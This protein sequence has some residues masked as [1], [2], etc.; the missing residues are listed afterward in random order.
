[1]KPAPLLRAFAVIIVIAGLADPVWTRTAS[2][3]RRLTVVVIEPKPHTLPA[4]VSGLWASADALR[5]SLESDYEISMATHAR[6]HR[7]SACPAEGGCLIVSNGS[8]PMRVSAGAKVIGGLQVGDSSGVAIERIDRPDHVN[9]LGVG[10]LNVWLRSA[11]TN[12]SVVISAFDEG[13]LVGERD[14]K[15]SEE[16]VALDWVPLTGGARRLRVVAS[17]REGDRLVTRDSADV[18]IDVDTAKWPL[19]MYEPEPTWLG[20]FVRRSVEADPR[21]RL[22]AQ[23]RF[24]P[25]VVIG[26][27][28][29]RALSLEA[30]RD[31]RAVIVSAPELLSGEEVQLLERFASVRGGSVVF[32]PDRRPSG[33]VTRLMPA[34][35]SERRDDGAQAVGDLKATEL[36]AFDASTD[37]TKALARSGERAVVV[38]RAIGRGHVIT[39]GALDAWRFRDSKFSRYW[40]SLLA[41]AAL[42]AGPNLRVSIDRS[43][44]RP[45]DETALTVQWRAM[46]PAPSRL[47]ATARQTC[48]SDSSAIRLW[49]SGHPG[50]LSGV[51]R[52]VSPGTCIIRAAITDPEQL[53]ASTPL[54]V[55]PDV[56]SVTTSGPAF[57]TAIQANGGI[58]VS[59]DRWHELVDRTHAQL[60][61]ERGPRESRPMRSPWWILPFAVC[62]GGEWWLRRR[63]GLR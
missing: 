55:A 11:N 15:E 33:P 47:T 36:L 2:V 19:L 1:M 29:G 44:L 35:V 4:A 59:E 37:G 54:V 10:R 12:G 31:K 60:P 23:T 41:D 49:P 63:A 62:L 53:E 32:L 18:A 13:M 58:V 51:V 22:D 38:S 43:A 40:S 56:S 34:I 7:A 57:V 46:D 9:A 21:F 20:T 8:T 28:N 3:R 27:R 30:L 50:E 45:G 14:T 42:T 24:G 6:Q 48:G 52:A 25:G 26:S 17:V 61:P 5:A 39:S 16:P